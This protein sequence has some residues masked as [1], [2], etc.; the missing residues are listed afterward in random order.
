MSSVLSRYWDDLAKGDSHVTRGR[1]ITETDV[2]AFSAL[3]GDFHPQHADREWAAASPFGERIAHGLLL[4]SYAAG[5]VPFDPERV[6]ALRRIGQVTF[7]RP[8]RIG[9]TI[10]VRV[11]IA[12]LVEVDE[13]TGLAKCDWQVVT[14]RDETA[15]RASVEVLWR[16]ASG[17]DGDGSGEPAAAAAD[18]GRVA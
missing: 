11:A 5:L 17:D 16:R 2:V 1:T 9:D 15:V 6:V 3:T 18:A 10:H 13:R 14:Q 8:V 7:K 12:D 4:L